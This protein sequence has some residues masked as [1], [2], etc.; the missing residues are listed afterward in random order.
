MQNNINSDDLF[1]IID[2]NFDENITQQNLKDFLQM[3]IKVKQSEMKDTQIERLYK[4]W[5]INK[6]GLI[7]RQEF[8]KI[9]RSLMDEKVS[10]KE[11][12]DWLKC[13]KQQ[14]GIYLVDKFGSIDKSF[15]VISKNQSQ[16]K[17]Q[18]FN[19]YLNQ[20]QILQ[21]FNLTE[22][23]VQ[24]LFSYFDRHSKGYLTQLDWN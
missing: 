4:L 22:R 13:A 19:N 12:F 10:I 17:F 24:Q 20:K 23:L 11:Q 1:R 15:E 7:N 21:G 16:L 18:E 9:Y 14:V 5:D 8:K 2:K 3:S 6:K